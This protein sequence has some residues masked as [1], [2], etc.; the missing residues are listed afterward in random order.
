MPMVARF[1]LASVRTSFHVR[2]DAS[3]VRSPL[4]ISPADIKR[5]KGIL[6]SCNRGK[7]FLI[8][9]LSLPSNVKAMVRGGSGELLFCAFIIV[10]TEAI[11]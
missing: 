3:P 5:V 2:T 9:E 10:S 8:N 7:A 1:D 6:L 11:L 4:S